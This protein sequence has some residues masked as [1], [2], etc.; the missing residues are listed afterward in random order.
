[1]KSYLT[2]DNERHIQESIHS[3]EDTFFNTQP[4][5]H[6]L[7]YTAPRT[8]SSIHSPEDTF[9]NTQPRGHVLQPT[10][11]RTRSSIHSP[12]DTFFNTQ[13]RGHVLQHTAPRTRSSRGAF[14]I[15]ESIESITRTNQNVAALDPKASANAD[16]CLQ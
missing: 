4:R 14:P 7:Q 8:R 16:W 11:P 5:G 10:A 12:E 1:M 15:I 9:F 6:V 2:N 3:P 13:P